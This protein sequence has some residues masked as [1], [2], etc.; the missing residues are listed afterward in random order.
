MQLSSKPWL[1]AAA[2]AAGL[3]GMSAAPAAAQTV[4]AKSGF[5]S[6]G[7]FDTPTGSRPISN[8][9]ATFDAWGVAFSPSSTKQLDRIDLAIEWQFNPLG[10]SN[11]FARILEGSSPQTGVMIDEA[12]VAA[13]TGMPAGTPSTFVSASKPLLDSAKTY[14]I[15]ASPLGRNTWQW[16]ES[17]DTA[18]VLAEAQRSNATGFNWAATPVGSSAVQFR[19]ISTADAPVSAV[20]EPASLALMLPGLGAVALLRRRKKSA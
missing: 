11:F 2:L 14:W 5:S 4:L 3:L 18:G 16:R 9:V 10:S 15:L 13:P 12:I 20:P 1:R 6:G 17:T 8:T 7:L 19:V